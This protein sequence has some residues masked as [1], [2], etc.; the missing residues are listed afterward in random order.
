MKIMSYH[1]RKV[2]NNFENDADELQH[3]VQWAL[4]VRL[5]IVTFLRWLSEISKTS[6]NSI[7][8]AHCK[9]DINTHETNVTD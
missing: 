9:I 8:Q 7:A 5:P 1:L 4:L 3:Y 2:W 6:V